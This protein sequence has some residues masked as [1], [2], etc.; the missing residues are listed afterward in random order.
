VSCTE[1]TA[2]LGEAA[3]AG[4]RPFTVAVLGAGPAGSVAAAELAR[5]GA[6]VALI[7]RAEGARP[8]VGEC[9]PPGIRPLLE[10]TGTWDAFLAA[11]HL[12]SAGIRSYW[13]SA[14]PVDRDF[15][16]SPYG[17]GWHLDRRQFD[18][19]LRQAAV[20][21]GACFVSCRGLHA[22]ERTPRGA[23]RLV[24][25]VGQ[26]PTEITEVEAPFV[27]EATGRASAFARRCGMRRVSLDRLT[28]L[29]GHFAAAPGA[30]PGEAVLLVEAVE[31]GWWYT[32]PLPGG[33]LVA[34]YMT[35][36]ALLRRDGLGDPARWT[37]R[38]AAAAATRRRVAAQGGRL[39]D[40]P[41]IV[42]AGSSFLA[43]PAGD[44][45]VAAGDAAAAFDPLS[46]Q[47]ITAAVTGGLEAAG[48]ALAW[49]GG[50]PGILTAFAEHSRRAYAGY[51]A[52]RDAYY[53]AE[54]RWPDS[55]FW[56]RRHNRL[57]TP[58]A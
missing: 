13:G 50:A 19:M 55:P 1:V 21:R 42:S 9:L 38:L 11:G 49:L 47:G 58:G 35:D 24:L 20:A 26:G 39:A 51:L 32:A 18:A 53:R 23:W 3:P 29:A 30:E 8:G 43:R 36:A 54:R 44:G 16:F 33:R 28:G 17:A 34:V 6:A 37:A 40:A 52:H 15:I 41:R 27:I 12:A 14:E 57:D 4:H 45:W 2:P 25:T 48:A 5:A 7:G 22:A 31:D 10:R 46:A 56:S